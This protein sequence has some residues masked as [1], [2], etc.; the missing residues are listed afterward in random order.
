MKVSETVRGLKRLLRGEREVVAGYLFGSLA[1]GRQGPLSD[2]DVAV[3]LR[4]DLTRKERS[5]LKLSLIN[6]VS[7]LLGT[8]NFDLVVMNGAP[9][10]LRYNIIKTGIP[11]K[12]GV[13]RQRLE[14]LILRDYLDRKYYD[15]LYDREFLAAVA[16]KG[17]L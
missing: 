15:D 8:D 17:I 13:A 9:L 14:F 4:G 12:G 5:E 11:L 6:D 7:S 3:F 10:L 2:V 1:E 16:K